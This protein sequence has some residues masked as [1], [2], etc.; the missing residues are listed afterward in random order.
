MSSLDRSDK[1]CSSLKLQ[2][3]GYADYLIYLNH[4]FQIFSIDPQATT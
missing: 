4:P 3:R 2:A 1:L